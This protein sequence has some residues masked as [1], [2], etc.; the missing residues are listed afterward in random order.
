MYRLR[1]RCRI[2]IYLCLLAQEIPLQ[3]LPRHALPFQICL[4]QGPFASTAFVFWVAGRLDF[5]KL[6]QG[7]PM[8]LLSVGLLLVC[9]IFSPSTQEPG[10]DGPVKI[11]GSGSLFSFELGQDRAH[12]LS[13]YAVL[14]LLRAAALGH[15][16]MCIVD[17]VS[18]ELRAVVVGELPEELVDCSP[19][20]SLLAHRGRGGLVQLNSANKISSWLRSVAG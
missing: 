3:V 20:N 13:K 5:E 8:G 2:P 9:P 7:L 15:G 16:F 17:N 14:C 12:Y 18:N 19:V 4:P 10:Q 1:Y 11:E 6:M